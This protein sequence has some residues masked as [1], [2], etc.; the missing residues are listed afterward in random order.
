MTIYEATEEAQVDLLGDLV[1]GSYRCLN[2][3]VV[4]VAAAAAVV[5]VAAPLGS[6][7]EELG[8][9]WL[10]KFQIALPRGVPGLLVAFELCVSC[11]WT[12]EC[13]HHSPG[14]SQ[15]LLHLPLVATTL[16][17]FDLSP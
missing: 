2:G 9:I 17:R 3:A 7:Q 6:E 10:P 5:V 16:V 15:R 14:L 11:L 8:P 13:A 1:L 12:N 4:I